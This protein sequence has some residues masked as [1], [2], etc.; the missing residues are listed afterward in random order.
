MPRSDSGSGRE[1]RVG[2]LVLV[3]VVLLAAGIFLIGEQGNLFSR[4]NEYIIYFPT[5]GGLNEGNPVQLNGV[6]VGTVRTV[7]LPTDAASEKIKVTIEVDRRYT[8]RIR[9]DS[10]ARIKTLGLLGDKFVELTS[11]SPGEELIPPGG[12][13]PAA[14]PTNV[15]KL[16]ASGEDVMDN[17]VQISADLRDIL[18]RMEEGEG[19]LGELTTESE[20][21]SRV[22]DAVIETME[23]VQRVATEIEQ[24]DGPLS[25]L[26][27][28]QELAES[29]TGSVAR[30]EGI[31]EKAETGD[32]LLPA[33]LNDP[34]TKEEF[35]ATLGQLREVAT[36]LGAL[37][38]E[39][40]EGD[41][42]LPRLIEDEELGDEVESELREALDRIN[43]LVR[44]LDEG[45][46]TA[47][48]LINDPS[49]YEAVQDVIVGVNES[50][51]LRWLIRNRQKKGIE[52]RY[53]EARETVDEGEGDALEAP[54]DAD[55]PAPVPPPGPAIGQSG[56]RKQ[57]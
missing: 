53:E 28:D 36:N 39:L 23:S 9:E 40:Q 4:K 7:V 8:E 52:E 6:E 44:K 43:N 13:I 50:R 35:D 48:K 37:S 32:G 21:G 45:E 18:Q 54:E 47:G 14:P 20:T 34:S 17:V 12:V 42:L 57:P 49:V 3:A 46:G 41:G 2:L 16:I 38:H 15:D 24:G 29:L 25:R 11:G 1:W 27:H 56:N 31:L 30:L 26:I 51:I 10:M 22:T 55:G 19:L 5:V 33:L